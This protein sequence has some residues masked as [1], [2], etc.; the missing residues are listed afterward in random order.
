M[1]EEECAPGVTRPDLTDSFRGEVASLR[2]LLAARPVKAV[3]LGL[4]SA[5]G[6][7]LPVAWGNPAA[8]SEG[9]GVAFGKLSPSLGEGE[10]SVAAVVT[11][12]E[13]I[14][15]VGAKCGPAGN[16]AAMA[17][18]DLAEKCCLTEGVHTWF[19]ASVTGMGCCVGLGGRPR[20][21]FKIVLFSAA[22]FLG[23]S[24]K[25][26]VSRRQIL[27]AYRRFMGGRN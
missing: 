19:A 11:M 15:V 9:H 22:R 23:A 5:Q 21:L 8:L 18:L 26:E 13:L 14:P 7:G 20:D 17:G 6:K 3:L 16:S 24:A 1:S 25:P 2:R 12:I 27:T 10:E 4:I